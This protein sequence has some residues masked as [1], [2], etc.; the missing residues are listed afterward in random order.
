M[1]HRERSLFNHKIDWGFQYELQNLD[2]QV[3]GICLVSQQLLHLKVANQ[4]SLDLQLITLLMVSNEQR[5]MECPFSLQNK[6]QLSF[7]KLNLFAT[8]IFVVC[9]LNCIDIKYIFCII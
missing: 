7:S 6:I 9:C 4:S 5:L 2:L 3:N 1:G 8:T